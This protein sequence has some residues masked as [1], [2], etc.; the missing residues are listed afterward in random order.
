MKCPKFHTLNHDDSK[1]CKE[2]AA[3]LTKIKD[4]SFTVTLKAPKVGFSKETVIAD[5]YKI[6]GEIGRGGMGVVYKA[7]DTRLDRTVAL[8]FLSSELT[9]DEE[10]KQRFVQEAKAAAALDHP[11]ICTVFEIDEADGQIFIAMSFIDGLSLKEKLKDGPLDVDEAKDIALRV[12]EGLKEAHTKGIIHRD[13]KPANI[14]LTEKGQAKITDFGLAKL[15]GGADLT[16]ASTIMGTVAYMS[17]EQAR[18]EK[19]DH[20]TDIWSLGALMHEMLVGERPFKKSHEQALIYSILNDEPKSVSLLRSGIPGYI[21]STILKALEKDVTKRFQKV[22]EFIEA[23]KHPIAVSTPE[24]DKSIAVLPFEDM[25]QAKDQEYFCDGITEEIINRLTQIKDFRVIARTSAFSFKGMQKDIKEIGRRLDVETVL[26][27]SVRKSGQRL[28]ITAQLINVADSSHLWSKSFD[29]ELEDIFAIQDEIS[30][31]IAEE[32]KSKVLEKTQEFGLNKPTDNLEAYNLYL[33]GRFFQ[34][35]LSDEGFKKSISFFREAIEKDNTF[36]LAY[37]ALAVSCTHFSL[38][39]GVA[40]PKE[41]LPEAKIA[42]QRA[43]ELDPLSA[44]AY[45]SMGVV[46]TW[47]EWNRYEAAKYF[48]KAIE[49]NPNVANTRF[50]YASYLLM[51]EHKFKEALEQLQKAQMLDPID[52]NVAL[53]MHVAYLCLGDLD[54]ALE[55]SNKIAALDP[56]NPWVPHFV[57]HVYSLKGMYKESIAEFE[58]AVHLGDRSMDNVVELGVQH[59]FAGNKEKSI[60]YLNELLE[61]ANQAVG[62]S[63]MIAMHYLSLNEVDA[64]FEWIERAYDEHDPTLL[65]VLVLPFAWSERFYQD[66]RSNLLLEKMGLSHLEPPKKIEVKAI[67]PVQYSSKH[68]KSIVVLPFDDVSPDKDN[69]YFSDGLTEEI[70]SDLSM[71]HALRV[72]SRTS[73]MRLKGT[74]KSMRTIAH[75]LDVQYVIEGSVRKAGNNLRIT[76]QLIDASNDAHL[77]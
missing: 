59:A 22:D 56:K 69:E 55:E 29:R 62:V 61:R 74:D 17:P 18:G 6:L 72:I 8:K 39:A 15:S 45:A 32:L 46:E 33:K 63:G 51:L 25:S 53:Y 77:W 4:V 27:G 2:C 24:D 12:A 49:L 54:K 73:A 11:N 75:E 44:E 68:E 43:V 65:W 20:R 28:R 40:P 41:V 71:L 30:T 31:A 50:W 23:V 47:Y 26:E 19:V 70:I 21:E 1:F 66:P 7:K 52:L 9:R 57:G 35:K 64:A 14:M 38:F 36:S 13:I 60:E 16:K 58:K 3:P 5:K 37:A 67:L 42:A 48:L 34:N 10:A 76:A